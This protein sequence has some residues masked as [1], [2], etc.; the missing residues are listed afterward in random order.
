MARRTVRSLLGL[1]ANPE[2]PWSV[3]TQAANEPEAELLAD[4]VA[5]QGIPVHFQ[6]PPGHD[7]LF[8]AGVCEILV[9]EERLAEARELLESLEAAAEETPSDA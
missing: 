7:P 9:P 1:G 4:L 8:F 2:S 6:R 5:Q 3:L